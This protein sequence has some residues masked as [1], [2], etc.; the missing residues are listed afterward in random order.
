MRM[1]WWY[2]SLISR[3]VSVDVKHHVCLIWWY[4]PAILSPLKQAVCIAYGVLLLLLRSIACMRARA[5]VCCT[6]PTK[7]VC[8][9][10]SVLLLLRSIACVRA[11][12]CAYVC[13]CVYYCALLR[14]C[15]RACV[16][17]CVCVC[18]CVSEGGGG[19]GR[20]VCVGG[21]EAKSQDSV[22]KPEDLKRKASRSGF[23]PMSV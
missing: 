2:S 15:V 17:V 8:I 11:C 22:H 23:D 16:R 18:V 7:T 12:V 6:V 5:R 9:A 3:T 20:N 14:A 19:R 13:A 21:G 10:Y 4:Q 1:A